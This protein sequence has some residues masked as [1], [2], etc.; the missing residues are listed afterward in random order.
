MTVIRLGHRYLLALLAVGAAMCVT[1][2]AAAAAEPLL[3]PQVGRCVKV[4]LGTGTYKGSYCITREVEGGERGK[5]NWVPASATENLTFAGTALEVRLASAGHAT[6]GCA[7]GNVTGT[8]TGAK[9]ATA[10]I[11]LQGCQNAL[12]EQCHNNHTEAQ[13]TSLPL[14]A[15]L[16]FIRNEVVNGHLMVKVGMDFKPQSP[17][18]QMIVYQC[19][20]GLTESATVEGSVIASDKPIDKL[21]LEDNLN[22]H[23]TLSGLQDPEMFEN[24]LKDTLATTFSSGLESTTAPSTLGMKSYVGKFSQPLEIKAKEK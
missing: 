10:Q 4:A 5:Y 14:E 1:S 22:F 2:T 8:F 16:G 11:E 17:L 19:G 9:T 20:S 24:G 3:L 7:V 13:I 23:V 18:T 15:E 6:V 21:T 12:G